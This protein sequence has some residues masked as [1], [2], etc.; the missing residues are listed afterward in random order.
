MDIRSPL[1]NWIHPVHPLPGHYHTGTFLLVK[2]M[3]QLIIRRG[4]KE[5]PAY[6]LTENSIT[7]GRNASNSI[8]LSDEKASRHHARIWKEGDSFRL[9]DLKSSNGTFLN[10]EIISEETLQPGDEIRVGDT[11]LLFQRKEGKTKVSPRVRIVSDQ[12]RKRHSSIETVIGSK[13]REFLTARAV[14]GAESTAK[15]RKARQNLATLYQIG[16]A[17]S[18]IHNPDQLLD[19]VMELIFEVIRADR[20]FL[21]LLDKESGEL[22]PRA[23]RRRDERGRRDITVS[24]TIINQV[25]RQEKSILSSDAMADERFKGGESIHLHEIRSAMCVPL[26]SREKTLGIIHVDTKTST[27]VFTADDLQLLAAIGDEAGVAIENAQLYQ[28]LQELFLS[29]VKSLVATIETKDTY[30]HGHSERV[31]IYS[32]ATAEELNL[33]TNDKENLQL[34]AVLHDIGKIGIPENILNKQGQ[35]TAEEQAEIRRHPL[36]ATRILENIA[37]LKDIIPVIKHHHERYDGKGYPDSLKGEAI[38]RAA[39]IIA[40]ADAFDALTSDRPYRKRRQDKFALEEIERNSNSQF[41]EEVVKAFVQ[42][43]QRGGMY[44]PSS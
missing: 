32:L 39:C 29:T 42:A 43:Y 26:R 19:K 4:S 9:A 5:L 30:T 22:V 38:P 20:G 16:Q 40:V 12:V 3:F 36:F 34:A 25:M 33:D 6:P 11:I 8:C 41:D 35:L 10:G 27:G 44:V 23:I 18:S 17:I 2:I 28:D 24:K 21:M 1:A 31:S 7:I 15:L 14:R 37:A 13:E